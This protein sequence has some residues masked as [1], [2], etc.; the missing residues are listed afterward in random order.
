MAK[1]RLPTHRVVEA[2]DVPFDGIECLGPRGKCHV[3]EAFLFQARKERLG[4]GVVIA[5]PRVAH[6]LRRLAFPQDLSVVV[7]CGMTSTIAVK[8]KSEYQIASPE[9]A[10]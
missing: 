9:R 6:A 4:N 7:R 5:V 3:M 10:G 1:G 2:I 8:D